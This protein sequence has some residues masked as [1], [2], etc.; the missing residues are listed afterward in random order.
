MPYF[1]AL[2]L[3]KA[4]PLLPQLIG[5]IV[6]AAQLLGP[7][8][9]ALSIVEGNSDDG[10]RDVLSNLG[11]EMASLGVN[12]TFQST[13]LDPSKED[14]I[15][16]LAALRN[17]ALE[18]IWNS[19]EKY[20]KDTTIIF[21]NDVSVCPDDVLELVK[22]RKNL[23]ADMTCA[24]DWTYAGNDPT[25]YDVWVA[26]GITGESFFLIPPDGSW[27]SAWNLFWNDQDS[28]SRLDGHLPFQV[29]SCWNGATAF[30]A[31]AILDNIRFRKPNG[32]ECTQ[33]EPQLFCKDLW[34]N[35]FGRIAVVPSINVEYSIENGIKIKNAKGFTASNIVGKKT[36]DDKIEW[37]QDPPE[38]VKCMPTYEN[39]YFQPWNEGHESQTANHTT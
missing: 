2:D 1:F 28:K 14:R 33:G 11:Q 15:G 31:Q 20:D 26:R 27:D 36:A 8:N 25:F 30:T 24:M 38:Q 37:R 9:C 10:T 12:Y 29:F 34:L 3:R 32:T 6:T 23:G 22:Q 35:G 17:L 18:P 5:S 19:P 13:T 7:E 21:L 16:R 4:L 39:Q